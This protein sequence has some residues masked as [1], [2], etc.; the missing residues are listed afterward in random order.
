MPAVRRGGAA[1]AVADSPADGAGK[2]LVE[3]TK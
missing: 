2:N 1:G 3:K